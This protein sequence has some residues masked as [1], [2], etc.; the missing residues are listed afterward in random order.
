MELK[1]LSLKISNLKRTVITKQSKFRVSSTLEK[2]AYNNAEKVKFNNQTFDYTKK[3][4]DD[5]LT[6]SFILPSFTKTKKTKYELFEE[7]E[8]KSKRQNALLATNY[9]IALPSEL[10]YQENMNIINSYFQK[11]A[12]KRE[13][14]FDICYHLKNKNQENENFHCHVLESRRK[15]DDKGEVKNAI[16]ERFDIREIRKDLVELFNAE[17]RKQN[18]DVRYTYLSN[19]EIVKEALKNND[20]ALAI[21]KNYKTD[22]RKE[23]EFNSNFY[24]ERHSNWQK[25][26]TEEVK[27]V[28]QLQ[29]EKAKKYRKDLSELEKTEILLSALLKEEQDLLTF[30]DKVIEQEFIKLDIN[31][32]IKQQKEKVEQLKKDIT[33]FEQERKELKDLTKYLILEFYN[34]REFEQNHFDD[35]KELRKFFRNR[36]KD[37]E[38][39]INKELVDYNINL[40]AYQIIKNEDEYINKAQYYLFKEEQQEEELRYTE[41]TERLEQNKSLTLEEI[42]FLK[43]MNDKKEVQIQAFKDLVDVAINLNEN[44]M[45]EH[46]YNIVSNYFDD[47][48]KFFNELEL[49]FRKQE[50]FNYIERNID[51]IK[52]NKLKY[53][54]KNE[55]YHKKLANKE[56]LKEKIKEI[57]D[58]QNLQKSTLNLLQDVLSEYDNNINLIFNSASKYIDLST[59]NH[60][61]K[62]F[63]KYVI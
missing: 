37:K 59:Q 51:D 15:I 35:K 38:V 41:L 18:I 9:I 1:C 30:K 10:S 56:K 2:L 11:L 3:Q 31:N 19:E 16:R 24:K 33:S 62:T 25:Q 22:T 46:F 29:K 20:E 53:I 44:E 28:K 60:I 34:S 48:N 8:E 14:F 32:Y 27:R 23:K 55:E 13:N 50:L 52:I 57:K 6:S 49:K 45:K 12:N 40:L 61:N 21:E 39:S 63:E 58:I 43:Q 54:K 36:L 5:F 4:V 17:L 26:K 42:E 47:K 7:L